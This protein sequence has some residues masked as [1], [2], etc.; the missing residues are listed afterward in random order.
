MIWTFALDCGQD[1]E[2][3]RHS[4]LRYPHTL[5]NHLSLLFVCRQIHA[6]TALLPYEL[7]TFSMLSPGRSY[8]VK[9]L[10]RRTVVQREVMAGVKWSW[11]ES[12][13]EIHS[14]VEWLRMG[15]VR[16]DSW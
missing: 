16:K 8:L 1:I 5:Q 9:F 7:K 6:E 10:E 15:R 12:A 4:E 13:P 11:Y 14:A 2:L 3:L